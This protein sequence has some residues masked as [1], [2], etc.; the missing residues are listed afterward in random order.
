MDSGGSKW[1]EN[2]PNGVDQRNTPLFTHVAI[3][4][5]H[6][7]ACKRAVELSLLG[8]VS[9]LLDEPVGYLEIINSPIASD[10]D[11]SRDILGVN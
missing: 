8:K 3:I 11:L 1:M 7:V 2:G 4:S 10:S 6:S 5:V 9:K